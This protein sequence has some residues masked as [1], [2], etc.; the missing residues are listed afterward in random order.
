LEKNR[1]TVP[2]EHMSLLASTKNPF[3]KEVLDAALL[4]TKQPDSPYPGSPPFSDSGSAGSRR[5]SVI[6]D[7]GCQS[8]VTSNSGSSTGPKRPVKVD[9]DMSP[10]QVCF[11]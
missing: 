10:Y 5:S 1:N 2:D 8:F 3:L 9:F 7:P 4:A 11:S 6:P